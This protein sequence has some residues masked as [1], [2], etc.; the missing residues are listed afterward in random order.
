MAKNKDL[1]AERLKAMNESKEELKQQEKAS[2]IDNIATGKE[3]K[4]DFMKMAGALEAQKLASVNDEYIKDTIYIRADLFNF[5]QSLCKVPGDKKYHVNRAYEMYLTQIY[6]EM[7]VDLS[8]TKEI[9][10]PIR[11]KK[12]KKK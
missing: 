7:D 8:E 2:V 9:E 12:H 4:P 5:L 6:K 1:I 10:E 11:L 3:D